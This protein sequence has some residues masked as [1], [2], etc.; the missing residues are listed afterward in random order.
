MMKKDRKERKKKSKPLK[1]KKSHKLTQ[2][3]VLL[4]KNH[5]FTR[6]LKLKISCDRSNEEQN[7]RNPKMSTVTM[8]GKEI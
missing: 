8:E 6:T 1:H 2:I 4:S 5:N 7:T 3:T